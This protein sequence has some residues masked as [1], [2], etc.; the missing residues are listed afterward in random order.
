MPGTRNLLVLGLDAASPP[1]LQSWA[2]DRT[3]PNIAKLMEEG[4]V[5]HTLNNMGFEGSTWPSFATGLNPAGHGFYWQEQLKSGTYRTQQ[6]TPA[7]FAHRESLWELLS[8][9][10]HRVVALDVPLARKSPGL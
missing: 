5:G 7:D 3:L 4:L 2:A 10:G 1:L 9:A 8:S 6:T